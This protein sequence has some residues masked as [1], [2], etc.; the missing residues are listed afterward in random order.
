MLKR[1]RKLNKEA[2][3]RESREYGESRTTLKG[4]RAFRQLASV[5]GAVKA[6]AMVLNAF[7]TYPASVNR[8][9]ADVWSFCIWHVTEY[10]REW[11]KAADSFDVNS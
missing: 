8:R 2:L 4:Y 6:S 5:Y 11:S 7:Q 10:G 9:D 3:I 1:N